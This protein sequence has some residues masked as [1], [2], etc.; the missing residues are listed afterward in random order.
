LD[1]Q[2]SPEFQELV[3]RTLLDY[4]ET[5]EGQADMHSIGD[6][7]DRYKA[8]SESFSGKISKREP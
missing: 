4:S 5:P 3:T 1:L 7:N 6:L 8:I 2:I